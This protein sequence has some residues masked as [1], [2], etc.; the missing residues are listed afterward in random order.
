MLLAK[1]TSLLCAEPHSASSSARNPLELASAAL[2]MEVARAD[3]ATDQVEL[4]TI[5]SL[6][7]A[8]FALTDDEVAELAAEATERVDAATCLF[9]FT[10]LINDQASID[11]KR[12]LVT[13][14]WRVAMADDA[15]SQYEEHLIRKVSDLLYVTHNDFLVAKLAAQNART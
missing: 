8:H 10:R 2:M 1:L 3:F 6:L 12:T 7:I 15:L 5:R 11:Q 4:D 13:L 14:M 9:E